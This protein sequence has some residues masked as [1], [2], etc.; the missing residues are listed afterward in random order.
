LL[1]RKSKKKRES[2]AGEEIRDSV[3]M[4]SFT[5]W[6]RLTEEGD[7][8]YVDNKFYYKASEEREKVVK[9]R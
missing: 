2:A 1:L 5:G 6:P 8:V 4:C 9:L 7:K 3:G